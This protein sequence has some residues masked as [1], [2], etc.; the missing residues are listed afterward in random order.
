MKLFAIIF[1]ILITVNSYADDCIEWFKE[2]KVFPS[3][4]SCLSKCVTLQADMA[5]FMCNLKCDLIATRNVRLILIGPIKS[6]MV[7]RRSGILLLKD[8]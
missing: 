6:K 3:D 5:T 1:V 7:A 2:N 8:P 4:K